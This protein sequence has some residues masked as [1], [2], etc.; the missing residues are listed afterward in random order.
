MGDLNFYVTIGAIVFFAAVVWSWVT[1]GARMW[2]QRQRN[3]FADKLARDEAPPK[4]PFAVYLRAF[5]HP[6]YVGVDLNL[7]EQLRT[8]ILNKTTGADGRNGVRPLESVLAEMLDKDVPLVGLGRPKAGLR[9]SGAGLVRTD[10]AEWKK[11]ITSL[12]DRCDL[13]IMTPAGTKGTAWE[14]EQLGERRGWAEKTV[15]FMPNF[16]VELIQAL[17]PFVAG[18]ELWFG[19]SRFIDTKKKPRRGGGIILYSLGIMLRAPL[20]LFGAIVRCV[21]DISYGAVILFTHFGKALGLR[22]RWGKA[23]QAGR[24]HGLAFPAYSAKGRLFVLDE[25]GKPQKLAELNDLSTGDLKDV[26]SALLRAA[27]DA[28]QRRERAQHELG[29]APTIDVQAPAPEPTP[30]PAPVSGA[31]AGT[32]E[33]VVSVAPPTGGGASAS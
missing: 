6:A 31:D 14:I 1:L 10:D 8:L 5:R 2:H 21:V 16:Q 17:Q 26:R 7:H 24:K 19:T 18:Y 3:A 9:G 15:Y 33:S 29:A 20:N 11:V 4:G 28:A 23:R 32:T 13:I 25:H 12:L 30:A 22:G 27:R